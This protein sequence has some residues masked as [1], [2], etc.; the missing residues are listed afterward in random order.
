MFSR[1]DQPWPSPWPFLLYCRGRPAPFAGFLLDPPQ[2]MRRQLHL[3]Y[4][5]LCC[6]GTPCLLQLA[7]LDLHFDL[8]IRHNLVGDDR[9]EMAGIDVSASEVEAGQGNIR[10][11]VVHNL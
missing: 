1:L 8:V 6:I 3:A 4:E 11:R 5:Y 10:D 7:S 9:A 2:S